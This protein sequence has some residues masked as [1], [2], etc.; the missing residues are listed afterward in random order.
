MPSKNRYYR[1]SKISKAK[2]RRLLRL[3]A[4]DLTATDAA[5]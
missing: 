2:F 5:Q 1:H 4:M 3:F